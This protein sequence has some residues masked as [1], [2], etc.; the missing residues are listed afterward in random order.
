MR[1]AR[2]GPLALFTHLLEGWA[3]PPAPDALI[4]RFRHGEAEGTVLGAGIVK[5]DRPGFLKLL[6]TLRAQGPSKRARSRAIVR[7]GLFFLGG[8]WDAYGARKLLPASPF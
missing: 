7:F 2:P 8:L 1:P 4:D 3:A 5:I 6:T